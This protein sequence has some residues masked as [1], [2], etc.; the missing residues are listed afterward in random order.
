METILEIF[1]PAFLSRNSVYISV[2]VGFVVPLVGV[3]LVLRRVVFLGVALPQVSSCG[4]AFAF[5][6]QGWELIPH[7]HDSA[8]ERAIALAGSIVFT[9]GTIL[10]LSLLE[11]RGRGL[12]EG[13]TGFVYAM[14]GAW[15]ILLLVKNPV[16]QHGMLELLHGQIIAV[17]TIDLALTAATFLPVVVAFV[18]FQKEF[19]LVSYD[20]DMAI[21]LKKHVVFWDALLFTLIGLT[22]SVSVMSVGP[23]VAFGF[24]LLPPLIAYQFARNTAQ[25]LWLSSAIGGVSAVAGFAVAYAQD[26]PVGPTDLAL[27]GFLYAVTF[28]GR[29]GVEL[30]RERRMRSAAGS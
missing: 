7:A 15:S 30:Y 10:V 21:T 19:L 1:D 13:R 29:K 3:Y 23:L 5:A 11:R 14:A 18:L 16:G 27:L 6:L 17:P 12:I 28:L 8:Q 4:I 22:I 26:L 9:I 2:L 20:R 24:L 25:F